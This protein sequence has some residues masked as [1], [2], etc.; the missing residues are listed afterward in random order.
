VQLTK[1][2]NLF[3]TFREFRSFSTKEQVKKKSE[4]EM[5]KIKTA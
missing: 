4:K 2:E 1:K 5:V 3:D